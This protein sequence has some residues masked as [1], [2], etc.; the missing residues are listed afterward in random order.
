MGHE[1]VSLL[2]CDRQVL[3]FYQLLYSRRFAVDV[4]RDRNL[5]I[6]LASVNEVDALLKL[7]V[8][9]GLLTEMALVAYHVLW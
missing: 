8:E 3:F 7:L 4:T 6:L 9:K 2:L 1:R 5:S